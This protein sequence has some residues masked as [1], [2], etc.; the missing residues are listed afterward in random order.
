LRSSDCF[1]TSRSA[2]AADR[3]AVAVPVLSSPRVTIETLLLDA[4]AS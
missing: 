1:V 3:V 2:G 4:P